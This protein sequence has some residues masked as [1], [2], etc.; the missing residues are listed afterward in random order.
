MKLFT[1]FDKT[2]YVHSKKSKGLILGTINSRIENAGRDSGLLKF[3]LV[4]YSNI[5]VQ[6]S[7]IIIVSKP[8]NLNGPKGIGKIIISFLEEKGGTLIKTKV[9]PFHYMLKVTIVILALFLLFI[10]LIMLIGETNQNNVIS[11]I[12]A[13]LITPTILFLQLQFNRANL[14][15][16]LELILV[17]LK[18]KEKP[19]LTTPKKH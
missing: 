19:L 2:Y 9:E 5:E 12:I 7:E 17:D 6:N 14:K 8:T 4:D 10:S 16:Y 1:I 13:W 3:L 11:L 18:I 15:E